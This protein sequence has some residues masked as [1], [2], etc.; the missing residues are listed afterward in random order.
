MSE[1][2]PVV[3]PKGLELIA[4]ALELVVYPAIVGEHERNVV[5][6]IIDQFNEYGARGYGIY[7]REDVK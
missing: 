1:G 3:G 2:I 4:Q 5:K 7:D 6:R